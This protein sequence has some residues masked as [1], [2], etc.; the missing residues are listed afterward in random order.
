MSESAASIASWARAVSKSKVNLFLSRWNF[1]FFCMITRN[2]LLALLLSFALSF[3]VA[4]LYV[5]YPVIALL[6][7]SASNSAET[8][9]IGAVAGGV[10]SFFLSMLLIVE[11][12]LFLSIFALLQRKGT[13]R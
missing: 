13:K 9:G 11:P 4:I 12:I 1:D 3:V 7:S 5:F 10:S 2:I 6:L 8:R